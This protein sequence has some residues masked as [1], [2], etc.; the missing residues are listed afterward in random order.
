MH[1]AHLRL[2][3]EARQGL[4]LDQILW[5]PAG[6]PWHRDS[7]QASSAQRLAMVRLAVADHPAFQVDS[8]E[9][10]SGLPSYTVPTLERLRLQYGKQRPL[11]LLLGADAFAGL[12]RWHRWTELFDLSHLAIACRPGFDLSADQ[13]PEEVARQYLARRVDTP[14][15]LKQSPAGLITGFAMTPLA[16]SATRIRHLLSCSESARYLLPDAVIDYIQRHQLYQTP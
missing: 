2:A 9:A 12:N 14:A 6:Q 3:E 11:V 8:T 13:L 1:L 16:I 10:E 7:P 15:A 5:I 4:G